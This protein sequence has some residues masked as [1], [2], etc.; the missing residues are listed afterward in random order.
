MRVH[1]L[2]YLLGCLCFFLICQSRI[3][4][5]QV[6]QPQAAGLTHPSCSSG[7][8]QLP[9]TVRLSF[10]SRPEPTGAAEGRGRPDSPA[11]K[12]KLPSHT[13]H[14]GSAP[15]TSL[16]RPR[17]PT[18][19]SHRGFPHWTMSRTSA[20]LD[21]SVLCPATSQPLMTLSR[22]SYRL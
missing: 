2:H 10:R 18:C 9:G 4:S 22:S 20:T 6:C 3:V 15:A 5:G 19:L 13:T 8:T 12:Q 14:N 17:A 11:S 21:A 1:L 7:R 16:A